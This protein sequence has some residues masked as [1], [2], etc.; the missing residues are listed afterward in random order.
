MGFS[1]IPG[2]RFVVDAGFFHRRRD[3]YFSFRLFAPLISSVATRV[4]AGANSRVRHPGNPGTGPHPGRDSRGRSG[5]AWTAAVPSSMGNTRKFRT[6]P[7]A[8]LNSKD[9]RRDD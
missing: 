8:V 2:G 9:T 7:K 3:F 5:S 4:V 1:P 6:R